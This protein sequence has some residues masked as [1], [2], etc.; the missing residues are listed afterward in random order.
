VK[1]AFHFDLHV[2]VE[3]VAERD[4][5]AEAGL[6]FHVLPGEPATPEK[7]TSVVSSIR[8][9]PASYQP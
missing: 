5:E 2:F 3:L 1:A 6:E 9:A 8:V 7:F 4:A